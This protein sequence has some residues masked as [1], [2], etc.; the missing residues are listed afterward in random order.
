MY[1]IFICI[2]FTTEDGFG[3][4][5]LTSGAELML[6]VAPY[7]ALLLGADVPHG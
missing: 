5:T 1:H 6:Q 7:L 2:K 3:C 4:I